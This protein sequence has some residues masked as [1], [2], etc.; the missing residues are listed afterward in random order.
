MPLIILGDDKFTYIGMAKI[1]DENKDSKGAVTSYDVTAR[2]HLV[3]SHVP[4]CV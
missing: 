1:L 3:L 4:C 2:A